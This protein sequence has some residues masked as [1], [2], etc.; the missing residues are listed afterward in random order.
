MNMVDISVRKNVL[1][2]SA[3]CISASLEHDI[4]FS[5]FTLTLFAFTMMLHTQILRPGRW[6]ACEEFFPK[7]GEN[8][9]KGA[10]IILEGSPDGYLR[11]R[12]ELE[13]VSSSE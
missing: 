11:S 10:L 4:A 6:S 3:Y 2:R 8:S 5:I 7:A 9:P 12:H 13:N 1:P